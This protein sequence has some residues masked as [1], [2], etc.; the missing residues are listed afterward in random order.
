M[1]LILMRRVEEQIILT[2]E[3]SGNVITLQVVKI[4]GKQTF[5]GIDAPAS[6]RIT[7]PDMKSDAIKERETG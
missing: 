5:I 2:D 7:R 6:V 4:N 1:M 3:D